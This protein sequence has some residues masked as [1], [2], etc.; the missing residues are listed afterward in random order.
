MIWEGQFSH[1]SIVLVYFFYGLGFF[2][3]GLAI[4]LESRWSSATKLAASLGFL[5]AFGLLH[6]VAGWM[7]MFLFIQ[8][9]GTI[10]EANLALRVVR[11]LLLAASAVALIYFGAKLLV[12]TLG[13]YEWL[14]IIPGVLFVLWLLSFVAPHLFPAGTGEEGATPTGVCFTCHSVQSGVYLLA[15]K[16]WVTAADVWTRYLLFFPGS[17]LATLALASQRNLFKGM[18]MP[19]IAKWCTWAAVAFAFGAV[20]I[21]LIVPPAPYFPASILNYASFSAA[22]KM[23]PQVLRVLDSLAVAYFV[24]RILRVFELEHSRKLA[25]ANQ[26][27]FQAQQQTLETQGRARE[28]MEELNR[29]LDGRVKE[30]TM[31]LEA[32]YDIAL[33]ISALLNLD[34]ILDSVVEKARELLKVDVVTL[35]L[36]EGSNGELVVRASSGVKSE[37]FRQ[38]R[39]RVGHGLAGRVAALGQPLVAENYREEHAITHELDSIIEEEGVRSHLAVPLKMGGSVLGVLYVATRSPRKF[40][41]ADVGL[42]SRLANQASIALENARLYSQVQQLAVLE[43]RDRIARE[44]HDSLAQ[45]LGYLS[46]KA[47][48]VSEYL[49]SGD[50]EKAMVELERMREAAGF[51]YAD[52]RESILGLRT[53]V[54]AG[55]GLIS[56]LTEYLRKFSLQN[57]IAADMTVANGAPLSFTP[58]VE[59]QLVRIIQEAL[60]NVRK[61]ASASKVWVAFSADDEEAVIS[62]RDNGKGFDPAGIAR[63]AGHHFGIQTMKERA[64]SV[65]GKLEIESGPGRGTTVTARVPLRR[66]AG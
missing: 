47:E 3:M 61:H 63:I 41:Q 22:F 62:I 36:L 6:G 43:E 46:L 30:R 1:I 9:G 7:D 19:Q 52:V 65:G 21:G 24:V 56:T 29:Q 5:A 37:A 17:V 59:V 64:E 34:K 23:P 16:E 35:S 31:E 32:L 51:A 55:R 4:A 53:T 10:P 33:E 50:S 42:L 44:M 8:T 48:R 25:L 58:P 13:K 14:Q 54:S 18:G 28:Q 40:V 38:L 39:M 45:A 20:V 2:T 27:R 11:V 26:E 49:V 15:S 57:G 12:S 66:G 60:T